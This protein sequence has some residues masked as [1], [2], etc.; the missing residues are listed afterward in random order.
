MTIADDWSVKENG[1]RLATVNA[2]LNVIDVYNRFGFESD[3][4]IVN[5]NGVRYQPMVRQNVR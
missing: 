5:T 2:S 3:G 1:Q 4:P